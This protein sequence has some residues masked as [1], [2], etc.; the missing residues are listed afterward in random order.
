MGCTIR[1]FL[2]ILLTLAGLAAPARAALVALVSADEGTAF[3]EA[4]EAI[5]TELRGAGHRIQSYTLPLR[6]EDGGFG[7]VALIVTLG[8]RAAQAV[9]AL[10]QHGPILHTLLP[11]SAYERLPRPDDPRR[12]SAVYIDQPAGR[13][14]ELIRQALPDWS[15]LVV[16]TSRDSAELG[17]RLQA[18]AREHRTLRVQSDTAQG[19]RDIYPTLQRILAEPAILI[20]VPDATLFNSSTISNILLTA[21]H[22]RSP[23]V[24]FS[25]AYVKAGALLA[26]Y[27]T[28]AQI[29]QH[30]G[31]MA[32]YGLATGSLPAAQYPRYFRVGTNPYVARSLDIPLEDANVLRE[33]LERAEAAQ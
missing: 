33:K 23:V 8:S 5:A 26:L 29:G 3:N 20:A 28:P 22:H 14:I 25:A 11:R 6:P 1:R 24:G 15:R 12:V 16:L 9:S 7:G 4:A 2:L 31:E 17:T 21:Y 32:R 19:E 13:Q 30:A 27:S 10:P 18:A